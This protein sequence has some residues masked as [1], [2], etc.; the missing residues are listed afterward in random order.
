MTKTHGPPSVVFVVGPTASGKSDL[1]ILIAEAFHGE[2]I[3]FDARQIYRHAVIGTA[4]P[5]PEDYQRVPHHLYNFLE[6]DVRFSAGELLHRTDPL[7]ADIHQRGR[8]PILVGGTGL[9]FRAL[10]HGLSPIPGATTY[11]KELEERCRTEGVT[12]LYQELIRIDPAL[13]SRI[14][15]RDARRVIRALE[16]YR[17]T[18]KRPSEIF[19]QHGFL[20]H[21]F[22]DRVV[23]L[24]PS[25]EALRHR[26]QQRTRRMFEQGW[27]D[28]VRRLINMGVPA[29]APVFEAIGYRSIRQWLEND[30]H[31]RSIHELIEQI[32]RQTYRYA[33]IQI[34]WFRREPDILWFRKI[35]PLKS[36]ERWLEPVLKAY[37][38]PHP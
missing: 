36:L 14:Q 2:I 6:P 19:Q 23:G 15:P 32:N 18:G 22:N 3:N 7:I 24:L 17:T 20:T 4:S 34:K 9:Y 26:I 8:L 5:P 28:E 38:G 10:R 27:I 1:A 31:N 16:I 13:K 29:H 11:R 35:P 30:S 25:R 21:R 12:S 33:R 37:P